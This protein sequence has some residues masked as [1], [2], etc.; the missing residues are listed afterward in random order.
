MTK[1]E[2]MPKKDKFERKQQ[3]EDLPFNPDITPEDKKTLNNQSQDKNRAG[4]ADGY[5]KD[6]TEPVR[7]TQDNLDIPLVDEKQ[8][9]ETRNK[10]DDAAKSKRPKESANSNDNIESQTETVYKG[11]KAEKYK[12]P[13]KN[14]RDQK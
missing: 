11:E 7:F 2:E 3:P 4:K 6:R 1:K 9:N 13:A 14:K 8:F 10:P 5:F 12:D